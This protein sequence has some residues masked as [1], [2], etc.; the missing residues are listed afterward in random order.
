[1]PCA[2]SNVNEPPIEVNIVHPK[3]TQLAGS[4]YSLW[5]QPVERAVRIRLVN[6]VQ[7]HHF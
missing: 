2:L 3:A 1:M 6:P 5:R 7:Q 4:H